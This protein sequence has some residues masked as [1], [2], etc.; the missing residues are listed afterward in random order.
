MVGSGF[1]RAVEHLARR[2]AGDGADPTWLAR[3]REVAAA[4][5]KLNA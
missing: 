4:C 5:S 2:I 1:A 3:A